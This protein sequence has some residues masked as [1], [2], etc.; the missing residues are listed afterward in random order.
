MY[1][2]GCKLENVHAFKFLRQFYNILYVKKKKIAIN[3]H[4]NITTLKQMLAINGN[5]RSNKTVLSCWQFH[6]ND[7]IMSQGNPSAFS[8]P[9]PNQNMHISNCYLSPG[10]PPAGHSCPSVSTLGRSICPGRTDTR[11]SRTPAADGANSIR[12]SKRSMNIIPFIST[13]RA[14]QPGFRWPVLRG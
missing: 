10:H 6:L 3:V 12:Y 13:R 8:S 5:L 7:L 9:R 14:R 1:L 4:I 2:I 11:S